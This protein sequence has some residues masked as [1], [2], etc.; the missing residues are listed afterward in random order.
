MVQNLTEVVRVIDSPRAGPA[1]EVR[2][3]QTATQHKQQVGVPARQKGYVQDSPTASSLDVDVRACQVDEVEHAESASHMLAW[4]CVWVWPLAALDGQPQDGVGAA[5]A[6][7]VGCG[8][9]LGQPG[10]TLGA[11]AGG[12][13]SRQCAGWPAAL[14]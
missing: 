1:T 5:A 10:E 14:G 13:V 3:D 7:V 8:R 12:H 9:Y 4:G 2:P 6:F 11:A